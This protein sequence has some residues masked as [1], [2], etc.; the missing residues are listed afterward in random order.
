MKRVKRN[1]KNQIEIEAFMNKIVVK[2]K[3]FKRVVKKWKKLE[4]IGRI[5]IRT[6]LKDLKHVKKF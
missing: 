3:K 2:L 1:W 5:G 4:Y 6:S